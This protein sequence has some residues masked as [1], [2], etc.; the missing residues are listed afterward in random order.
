MHVYGQPAR[1]FYVG[2]THDEEVGRAG[3]EGI[4]AYLAQQPFGAEGEFEFVLD[5]GTVIMEEA[6][7]GLKLP[8]AIISVA[9][10]GYMTVEYR[11]DVPPGH[12]SISSTPTAIG[13]L[14]RGMDRLES[15]HQPSRFGY[16]PEM[17]LFHGV[18]P[19]LNSPL[20]LAMSNVWLFGPVIQ[21]VLSKKPGTNA[22]QRTTTAITL[23]EGGEKENILPASAMAT[24]NRKSNLIVVLC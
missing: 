4:A 24:I 21:W 3:S 12:A 19:Y 13:I 15:T 1:T 23:I 7:P 8:V 6:F 17:A 5:E 20:R 16:G 2:I 18:T 10:K 11:V 9:E 22:I 14:A